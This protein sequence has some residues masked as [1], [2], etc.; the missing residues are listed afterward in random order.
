[1]ISLNQTENQSRI[2][3]RTVKNQSQNE[4]E[5]QTQIL[6]KKASTKSVQL[7]R[8]NQNQMKRKRKRN[9]SQSLVLQANPQNQVSHRSLQKR[10]RNVKKTRKVWKN[11]L[12]MLL[13]LSSQERAKTIMIV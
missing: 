4:N 2:P 7:K 12:K 9:Q 5:D 10:T 6:I 3:T 1:M 11:Q 8:K 13:K